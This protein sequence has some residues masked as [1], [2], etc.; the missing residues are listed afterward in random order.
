MRVS[1]GAVRYRFP[2]GNA[3][4]GV[5]IAPDVPIDRRIA[6]IAAGRDVGM[7]RALELAQDGLTWEVQPSDVWTG[8]DNLQW[9]K[10]QT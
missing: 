1:V 6:D 3:F 5:G 7:A 4:E 9:L 8:G 10:D 2:D